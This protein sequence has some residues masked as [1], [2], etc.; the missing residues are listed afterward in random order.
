MTQ[1][2]Q[3]IAIVGTDKRALVNAEPIGYV[4]PDERFEVT[5]RVRA[6]RD[7]AAHLT[8][9]GPRLGREEF[10]AQF[11]A[12][13]ADLA[14][15]AHFA[16]SHGL[17]V[18]HSS[19]ARRSVVLSG[20]AAQFCPAFGVDLQLYAH[21]GG[22]TF[23]GREGAIYCP[24][25]LADVVQGVFGLDNRPAARA[26]F[27]SVEHAAGV[28]PHAVGQSFT[29]VQI[30]QLYNFPQ[31]VNGQGQCVGIIELGGGYTT[32]DLTEYFQ[33]LGVQP[34]PK[35][36]AVSVDHAQN[37]PD[38][39][40]G[41]DGEVMLDIEVVGAVAPGATIAVYFAPNTDQGFIDAITTAV[42][43]ATNQP[44]ILSISWG[45]P[46]DA[47]T[48]AST[49]AMDQAFQAAAAMGVSVYAAAGD[50]GA[51]DYPPGSPEA[52]AGYHADFPASSPHV[53]G[54]GGTHISVADN[55]ISQ[56]VVW[57]DPGGG[58]TGGGFSSLFPTPTWQAG[59]QGGN[60]GVPDVCGNASPTSGYQVRVDGQYTVIGGTS[61]VA[62][63]WAGLT[64]LLNQQLGRPLGFGNP[65]FYSL[66]AS[67]GAF[68]D[69]T[70][71]HNNGFDAGTG[72]DACTGLGRPDGARLAA[73]LSGTAAAAP[74]S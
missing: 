10:A 34:A 60:R 33:H 70:Q 11:G 44:S 12:D 57:N 6:K 58:S 43:D 61:A 46:E 42:H 30:A 47:W 19:A 67:S 28:Q 3:R 51:N 71:G 1:G 72:W 39:P 9:G 16:A 52:V 27:R 25:E 21:P 17:A 26:H 5:V 50:N 64:A 54:C 53:T 63:L 37:H 8:A 68:V 32:A 73:A 15:V 69:I 40:N 18:V 38:G 56:E 2:P 7:L 29:P 24:A 49:Q 62:P 74:T 36:L 55:A 13:P 65:A 35:V 41:A 66:S 23:R 45:S 59:V 20:T 48:Q 14:K 22:G 4:H 31:A